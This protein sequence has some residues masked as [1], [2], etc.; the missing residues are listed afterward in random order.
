MAALS[1]SD[2]AFAFGPRDDAAVRVSRVGSLTPADFDASENDSDFPESS[3]DDADVEENPHLPAIAS[4]ESRAPRRSQV[5]SPSDAAS[6]SPR[7]VSTTHRVLEPESRN[8][9]SVDPESVVAVERVVR[10][11]TRAA[12]RSAEARA[13]VTS[14]VESLV[15]AKVRDAV[16]ETA[17]DVQRCHERLRRLE[18]AIRGRDGSAERASVISGR[19]K[20]KNQPNGVAA[21][22][23]RALARDG[24]ES[25]RVAFLEDALRSLS[26]RV[27][28]L[29]TVSADVGGRASA[30]DEPLPE[31]KLGG[32]PVWDSADPERG[33]GGAERSS[34]SR[35]GTGTGPISPAHG[36][37][38]RAEASRARAEATAR[39]LAALAENVSPDSKRALTF[40]RSGYDGSRPGRRV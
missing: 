15:E 26:V 3:D 1:S 23:H 20:E 35:R 5:A 7:E 4:P 40:E 34:V 11:A 19:V 8:V 37:S 32:T 17:E 14:V 27:E 22:A 28:A 36:S 12:M 10:N 30:A 9:V 38:A 25:G 16:A 18:D 13:V 39:R 21:R 24:V 2:D 31:S 29:E 33:R 6:S